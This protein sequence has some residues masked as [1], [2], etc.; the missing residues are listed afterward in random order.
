LRLARAAEQER[1]T[2]AEEQHALRRVATLVAQQS[3]PVHVFAVVTDELR[4]LLALDII[5]LLRFESDGTAVVVAGRSASGEH[6]PEGTRLTL[7]GDDVASRVRATGAPSRVDEAHSDPGELESRLRALGARSMTGSP[8]MVEGRLWGV[9]IAASTDSIRIPDGT[10]GRVDEFTDL[11]AT[12][13]ANAEARAELAASRARVIEAGDSARRRLER[14]LHD[15]VQQRLVSASLDIRRAEALASTGS[16]ELRSQLARISGNLIA[17]TD[18]LRE[19]AHGIHPTIL[20]NGGIKPA[21]ASLVRRS[22]IPADLVVDGS[23]RLP[24][25]I[26]ST[27]YYVVSEALTN[28]AKH[29]QA[30]MVDVQVVIGP[31]TLSL[32]VRDDGVGGADQRRGSGLIGLRDRVEA[33]GGTID[34][35][36]PPGQGTSLRVALPVDSPGGGRS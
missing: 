5:H 26:E 3:S 28:A 11:V 15:G 7:T 6:V 10:Q 36:S 35:D 1:G 34:V 16:N 19:V 22:G 20:S 33:V 32:L 24:D 4:R 12:V 23:G 2:L 25:A 31:A 30:T 8:I 17:A 27:A 21:L 29:A 14:D 18:D 13:I 9:M